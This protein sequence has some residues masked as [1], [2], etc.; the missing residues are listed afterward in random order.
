MLGRLIQAAL[1]CSDHMDAGN[2]KFACVILQCRLL[3]SALQRVHIQ[4]GSSIPPSLPKRGYYARGQSSGHTDCSARISRPPVIHI[5]RHKRCALAAQCFSIRVLGATVGAHVMTRNTA[6]TLDR[7]MASFDMCACTA[8]K[9]Y[10]LPYNLIPKCNRRGL[11]PLQMRLVR[12]LRTQELILIHG[13]LERESHA[14]A[15]ATR[16]RLDPRIRD[17][18]R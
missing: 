4:A 8:P 15:V 6:M 7:P 9:L 14:E 3:C 1:G 11:G 2:I 13:P 17:V 16:G 18:S 12:S 10:D 5:M